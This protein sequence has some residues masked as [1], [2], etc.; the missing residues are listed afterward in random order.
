[1]AAIR[2]NSQF[3]ELC[4]C[5]LVANHV[6]FFC[7][8]VDLGIATYPTRLLCPWNFRGKNT[9]VGCYFFLQEIF[10]TKGSSPCVSCVSHVGNHILYHWA[11]WE[12]LI[13]ECLH[14]EENQ[15]WILQVM[16]FFCH[17]HIPVVLVNCLSFR[18]SPWML[19]EVSLVCSCLIWST[20]SSMLIPFCFHSHFPSATRILAF[21]Y[22]F[23]GPSFFCLYVLSS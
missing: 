9:G 14:K 10:I 7:D 2:P 20:Y 13:S 18:S 17:Q 12:A 16:L 5:C 15:Q 6:W 8:P 4:H 21:W 11:T 23:F 1:M 22:P 3:C 19:L